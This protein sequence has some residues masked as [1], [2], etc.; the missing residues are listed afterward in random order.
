MKC[1]MKGR[2]DRLEDEAGASLK[3]LLAGRLDEMTD[4]DLCQLIEELPGLV[5][6]EAGRLTDDELRRIAAGG[7]P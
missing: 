1:T 2:I 7:L 6:G 4:S 5:P 3:R